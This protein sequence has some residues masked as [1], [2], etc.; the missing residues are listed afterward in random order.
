MS[1]LALLLA[2]L[3]CW[4]TVRNIGKYHR[5]CIPPAKMDSMVRL[6]PLW[7]KDSTGRYQYTAAPGAR[8]TLYGHTTRAGV[9]YFSHLK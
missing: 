9:A 1:R 5:L 7:S 2:L 4:K 3:P 8:L 6:V